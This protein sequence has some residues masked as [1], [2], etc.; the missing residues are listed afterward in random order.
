MK[1]IMIS[2]NPR[3]V[4]VIHIKDFIAEIFG[5]HSCPVHAIEHSDD[6]S[7]PIF[8][9]EAIDTDPADEDS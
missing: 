1:F 2:Y 3:F 8:C 6:Q 7:A 9:I 4:K 5:N